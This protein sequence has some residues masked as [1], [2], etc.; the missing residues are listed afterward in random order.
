MTFQ[1]YWILAR[2]SIWPIFV[3]AVFI[4]IPLAGLCRLIA[5]EMAI[6]DAIYILAFALFGAVVGFAVAESRESAIGAVIPG[7][8][9]IVTALSG[10]AFAKEALNKYRPLMGFIL[11][12]LMLMTAYWLVIGSRQRSEYDRWV[13]EHQK[14]LLRF[15]KVDLE[16]EKAQKFKDAGLPLPT[17]ESTKAPFFELLKPTVPEAPKG[18]A[19]SSPEGGS[20]EH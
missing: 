17:V 14:A 7:V 5:K 19:G 18:S 10:F 13:E 20:K 8:L 3:S 2:D 1:D 16:L 6:H 4:S 12:A 15:E 11:L 9:T